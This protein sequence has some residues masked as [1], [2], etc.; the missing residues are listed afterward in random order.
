[1]EGGEGLIVFGMRDL[2]GGVRGENAG[3]SVKGFQSR[4]RG[5]SRY[6]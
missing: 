4:S 5:T 2:K 6:Q 1:M 3:G